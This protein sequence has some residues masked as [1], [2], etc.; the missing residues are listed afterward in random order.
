VATFILYLFGARSGVVALGSPWMELIGS[1][2]MPLSGA[3]LAEFARRFL[4]L[5][6]WRAKAEAVGKILSCRE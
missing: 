6:R 2:A 5:A 1:C 3:F 4:D